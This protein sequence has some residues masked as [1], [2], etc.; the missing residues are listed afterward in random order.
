MFGCTLNRSTVAFFVISDIVPYTK[1]LDTMKHECAESF[2]IYSDYHVGDQIYE[3]I[4]Y[5]TIIDKCD[6]LW[7]V[8]KSF[9]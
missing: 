6:F 4:G 2:K 1:T 9:Y 5:H 3:S 7:W 8:I